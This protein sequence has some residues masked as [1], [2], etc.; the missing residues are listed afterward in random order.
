MVPRTTAIPGERPEGLT[1]P[2]AQTHFTEP[3]WSSELF[4]CV[5]I[6]V[7]DEMP[8]TLNTRVGGEETNR[9]PGEQ[10]PR[11]AYVTEPDH[12]RVE[13]TPSSE[14]GN[15]SQTRLWPL[16][17]RTKI[18]KGNPNGLKVSRLPWKSETHITPS[19]THDIKTN[20]LPRPSKSNTSFNLG[21]LAAWAIFPRT[22]VAEDLISGTA[23]KLPDEHLDMRI[24]VIEPERFPTGEIEEEQDY[25]I[26]FTGEIAGD[27]ACEKTAL[28]M[29]Y[30]EKNLSSPYLMT[31][32]INRHIMNL[33]I[34]YDQINDPRNWT[35]THPHDA[36]YAL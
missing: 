34:D 36:S 12:T 14:T 3:D 8:G 33:Y 32:L 29:H 28:I 21:C 18:I 24:F 20:E 7:P 16:Y 2:A 9:T 1:A 19:H 5:R 10:N 17:P 31:K 15:T 22:R 25:E 6:E 13:C 30:D 23:S 35:P 11:G 26:S 27:S 4:V